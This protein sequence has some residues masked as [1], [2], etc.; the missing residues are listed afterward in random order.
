MFCFCEDVFS[1]PSFMHR[2]YEVVL[3]RAYSAIC[4]KLCFVFTQNLI[5][6]SLE[7][8]RFKSPLTHVLLLNTL[9][10]NNFTAQSLCH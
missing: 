3:Q 9:F 2:W 5:P 6:S 7:K 10:L 4:G 1:K 8:P